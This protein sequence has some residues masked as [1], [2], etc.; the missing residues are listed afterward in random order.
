MGGPSG[1]LT[2]TRTV[3]GPS[4]AERVT[5][6]LDLPGL[7]AVDEVWLAEWDGG[8]QALAGFFGDLANSWRGWNGTKEWAGGSGETHLAATH[9]GIGHVILVV[10]MRAHWKG[11]PPFPD[12]WA[13]TGVLALEPGALGEI[14]SGVDAILGITATSGDI[15]AH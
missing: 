7:R 6:T 8:P 12:E 4:L 11:R 15:D 5:W 2:F 1:S 9:D 3:L 13:A 14:A 10:T